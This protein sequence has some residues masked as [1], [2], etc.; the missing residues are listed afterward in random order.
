MRIQ[1]D[2]NQVFKYYPFVRK[3]A[4]RYFV[5]RAEVTTK[6]RHNEPRMQ[7]ERC[8]I[9]Q[10]QWK[11]YVHSRFVLVKFFPKLQI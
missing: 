11:K 4:K 8:A 6:V 3:S 1:E 10:T 5:Q 2:V 9:E 7:Q